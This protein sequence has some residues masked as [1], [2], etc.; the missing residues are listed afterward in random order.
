MQETPDNLV[1]VDFANSRRGSKETVPDAEIS[2]SARQ[3]QQIFEEFLSSGIVLVAFDPRTPNTEVPSRFKTLSDLRLNFSYAYGIDDFRHDQGGIRATLMFPEG[4]FCCFVPW[5]AIFS[6]QSELLQ[7]GSL[8]PDALPEE[9]KVAIESPKAPT[10]AVSKTKRAHLT[11]VKN[12]D[13][14]STI[15]DK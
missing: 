8:W 7:K 1:S 14:E 6:I 10:K 2:N 13:D 15:T 9:L 5:D 11:L 12:S 4:Y 3:K